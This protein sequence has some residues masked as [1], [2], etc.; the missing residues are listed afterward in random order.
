M[1]EPGDELGAVLPA[2]AAEAGIG[3]VPVYVA[4]DRT[5]IILLGLLAILV[6]AS[7]NLARIEL[8]PGRHMR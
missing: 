6:H 8:R 2:V 1:R 4:A 3:E 5:A 7:I